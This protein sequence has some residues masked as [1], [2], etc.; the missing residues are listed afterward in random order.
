MPAIKKQL[1]IWTFNEW[2]WEFFF[3][4]LGGGGGGKRETKLLIGLSGWPTWKWLR[5][6]KFNQTLLNI[7]NGDIRDL[8]SPFC[9]LLNYNF[10]KKKIKKKYRIVIMK[11]NKTKTQKY[12]FLLISYRSPFEWLGITHIWDFE[13]GLVRDF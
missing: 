6:L 4:F 1:F 5:V 3:F 2:S 9:H 8:N 11:T 12:L 7:F 10:Y 13:V